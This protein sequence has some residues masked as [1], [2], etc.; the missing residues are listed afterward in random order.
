MISGKSV[1]IDEE[2]LFKECREYS[3]ELWKHL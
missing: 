1:L 3:A 2:R